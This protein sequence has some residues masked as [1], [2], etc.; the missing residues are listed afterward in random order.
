MMPADCEGYARLPHWFRRVTSSR[1]QT[2]QPQGAHGHDPTQWPCRSVNKGV[3]T[4]LQADNQDARSVEQRW[5]VTLRNA[6]SAAEQCR[7][8]CS[9]YVAATMDVECMV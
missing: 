8:S 2:D 1:G 4:R 5:R 3:A 7:Y 6:P 9:V